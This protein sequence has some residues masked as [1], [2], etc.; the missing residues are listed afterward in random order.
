MCY[1]C[2][3]GAGRPVI[4]TPH[5]RAAVSATNALY[6]AHLSGGGMHIVTDD[7]NCDDESVAFC[8]RWIDENNGDDLERACHAAFS[9]LTE[10]ERYSA[11]AIANGFFDPTS[12]KPGCGRPTDTPPR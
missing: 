8:G 3:E 11:L 12:T 5:V 1:E 4:D 7:W 9:L 6:D 2:W 10:S